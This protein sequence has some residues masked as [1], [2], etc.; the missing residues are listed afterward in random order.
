MTPWEDLIVEKTSQ[1]IVPYEEVA[2]AYKP[3]CHQVS[4][5]LV[6]ADIPSGTNLQLLPD[7][8]THKY[9]T[10]NKTDRH[11]A[12]SDRTSGSH[13]SIT[14]SGQATRDGTLT[15]QTER[16]H[17]KPASSPL[18]RLPVSK[19][20]RTHRLTLYLIQKNC[21][22]C[23]HQGIDISIDAMIA[24]IA[25]GVGSD[26]QHRRIGSLTTSVDWGGRSRPRRPNNLLT[27]AN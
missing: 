4:S 10:S 25:S 3:S 2:S 18:Q 19:P 12:T 27:A 6:P 14:R 5:R 11:F 20:A 22:F 15:C 1:N 16:S 24:I 7:L 9:I 26:I 8:T 23:A 21:S 13:Q 17:D